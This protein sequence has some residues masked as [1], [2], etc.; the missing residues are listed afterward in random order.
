MSTTLPVATEATADH[1]FNGYQPTNPFFDEYFSAPGVLR[2]HAQRFVEELRDVSIA[3]LTRR[4]DQANRQ[5]Y[6]NSV[7]Y[8]APDE[9]ERS[10]RPWDFDVLPL[11]IQAKEWEELSKG[12]AQRAKLLNL[13]LADIYGAQKLISRGLLP[14]ELIYANPNFLRAFHGLKVPDEVF[15]HVYA[16]DLA[17]SP[18]GR[19][20]VVSDRTEMPSGAG[21]AL[22]NRLI[23]SGMY[24]DS[25][26]AQHVQRLAPFFMAM[27][28]MLQRLATTRRD[29]P[30]IVL[31]S[32]GPSNPNYFE[33]AYLSRYLGYMVVEGGDLAVRGDQ[34]QLKTLGGLM[35]VDA[36]LRRVDDAD[37]DPL[38]LRADSWRGVSGLTQAVR[39]GAV[40]M[41]NSLGSGLLESPAFLSF[42][43]VLCRELL[44]QE[45]QIPSLA[46]WWCGD[47][48]ALD[49]VRQHADD[50][51][52]RRCFHNRERHPIRLSTLSRDRRQ[53]LLRR[54]ETAPEE[55]VAQEFVRRSQVP[56]WLNRE[57]QPWH[58]ALRTYLVRQGDNYVCMPGGLARVSPSTTKLDESISAGEASKDTWVLSD[59]PVAGVSLLS[60]PGMVMELRRSGAE[61]PSRIAD[62]LFWLGRHVERC[63]G[64]GRLLRTFVTR[65]LSEAG[66]GIPELP[67]LV[68]VLAEKGLIEPDYAIEGMS[69]GLPSIES[70]LPKL[71]Y[72]EEESTSLRA[73][74]VS[75]NR[76]ASL[77]RERLS[78]DSW[79][80]L[81]RM[82][83]DFEATNS[84]AR[85][86]LS[87]TLAQLDRL[88]LDMA[89]FS[90]MV[91]ESMTR[92]LGWRFLDI[93]R[94]MERAI[95]VVQLVRSLLQ[96]TDWE[97]QALEASLELAD[98]LITYRS[99]YLNN[100][101]LTPVLDLLITDE[102]NPRSLSYQLSTLMEH[103]EQLPRDRMQPLRS[104]EQRISLN[105]LTSVRVLADELLTVT[106]SQLGRQGLE[107]ILLRLSQQLPRLSDVISQKYLIHAG[108]PRQLMEFQIPKS[109]PADLLWRD[110]L[111]NTD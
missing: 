29:N 75:M 86:D 87:L 17:R 46:T 12:L 54:L 67:L 52:L 77:V 106:T 43:P 58:V 27:R 11:L 7:T 3:E 70:S 56:S 81:N 28:E 95:H 65:L 79:R 45:L 76:T 96:R 18:D 38:E 103:V 39:S 9:S 89:A 105:L 57:V 31:L 71:V 53:K 109:Q 24:P 33:D 61:L 50:L 1:L 4:R 93:G 49:H 22:E 47:R 99:R 37:C 84:T 25:F 35:P 6:E 21:Y 60:K 64:A 55:F 48:A 44:G 42:L 66:G 19:W 14:G 13:I 104:Q 80:V 110:P 92:T 73:M 36:I 30:R 101:Q 85:E 26:R 97:P 5:I 2:P 91:M 23:S 59:G 107:R 78:G 16:A 94:R 68:R 83:H 20:W 32:Q 88:I 100:L 72:D 74:I 40:G 34:V 82:Y 90:G 8:N 10:N 111:R 63:D 51:C 98:S 108:L 69:D 15:L 102:S 62:N 41:A